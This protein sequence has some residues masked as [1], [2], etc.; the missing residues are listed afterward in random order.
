[1]ER[2]LPV[3]QHR[4]EYGALN[5][6]FWYVKALDEES[7]HF[8]TA[9]VD[10]SDQRPVELAKVEQAQRAALEAKYGKLEPQLY[11]L[12][13]TKGPDDEVNIAVWFTPIDRQAILV[14]LRARYPQVSLLVPER[15]WH[16]VKDEVLAERI[17]AD[18]QQLM[19]Q[20]HLAKQETLAQALRGRGYQVRLHRGVPSL[21][22]RL[23]KHVILESAQ[24]ADVAQLYLIEGKLEPLLDSAIPTA[25]GNTVWNRG[26]Q[27]TGQR[28]AIVEPDTLPASH[29]SINVIAVRT[30]VPVYYHASG[31]ASAAASHHATYKGMAP[32]AEIVS[33]GV[34]GQVDSW[35]DVDDAILWAYNNYGVRIMNASFSSQTGQ[36]SDDMQWIDRVFDYYARYYDITMIAAAGNQLYGNHIGSPAKGYN[37]IAVGGTDD[38]NNSAWGDDVIASFSAWK[39]PKRADGA[40]G[41]RE[42]PE[43]VAAANDLTLLNEYNQTYLGSGTSYSAPQVAGLAALLAHRNADLYDEPEAMRAIIMASAIHNTEGPSNI[44]TGQDLRDGAGAIDAA[45]ADDIAALGYSDAWQYPYPACNVPCWWFNYI[46]NALPGYPSHFPPGT[47]RYYYFQASRGERIR[48]ALT[49][50]S[51]P[52]GLV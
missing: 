49:W 38:K 31:V 40:Y 43:V 33:A 47:Y 3:N 6:A 44:P 48:V 35:D 26:L 30:V 2:L 14:E 20:A 23:P 17:R 19:E 4:R 34:N 1:M 12:L 15:P 46:Y 42:K 50:D 5:K 10:L 11:D 41:D 51:N 39:N 13:Q 45:I 16:D 22:A 32:Q 9:M 27:G 28:I 25:R 37:V 21:V 29:P 7:R 8:Y 24:R 36:Q 18:Y 52:A